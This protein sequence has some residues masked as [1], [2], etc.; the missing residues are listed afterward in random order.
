MK[1]KKILLH[2][3]LSM[4]YV[5]KKILLRHQ[6]IRQPRSHAQSESI[7]SGANQWLARTV[8][9]II[10]KIFENLDVLDDTMGSNLCAGSASL[11]KPSGRGSRG[12]F[13]CC[14]HTIA[15]SCLAEGCRVSE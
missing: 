14:F 11:C 13:M 2:K 1:R 15:T 7:A 4:R 8:Y 10:E 5:L 6:E 3:L 12:L 9:L